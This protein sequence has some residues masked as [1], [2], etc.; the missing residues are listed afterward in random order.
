MP[1]FFGYISRE[2]DILEKEL[3]IYDLIEKKNTLIDEETIVTTPNFNGKLFRNTVNKF[4]GDKVFF[5]KND[6]YLILDG[7][8]L[9][10]HELYK[11]YEI[12]EHNITDLLNKMVT[13][14]PKTF[15]Q[16]F[17]GTFAGLYLNKDGM[18]LYT[19]H[20]GD[21]EIFYHYTE[22]H[23]LYFATDFEVLIKMVHN[24]T[25]K[26]FELNTNAA[27][28]LLTHSHVL[29]NETLFNDV[30]RLTPGH[31]IE[32]ST[33]RFEKKPY[34]ILNNKSVNLTEEEALK[35]ID[36]LFRQAIKRA[37][38]KD[39]EYGYKHLVALSG[40]LDSRMT[41][42][43][44]Y[45]MGYTN[46]LNYTFSQTDYLDETVPKQITSKLKTEW[47]FKA[48]DNGTYLYKYFIDSI[49]ISGARSQSSTIAHTM[50]MISNINLNH[51]GLV[52]TGQIGD[53]V[54]G[55]FY[56][57]GK[58]AGFSRGDG[59]YSNKLIG[60]V[61]YTQ[62]KTFNQEDQEL[63]KFYNRG[64]TGVN[65]GLKPMYQFT[66]TMSPF[67]DIDFMDFC[68]TMPMEFRR[69]HNIYIKW[70]NQ[71]YPEAADFIYEKVKG[72]INRK[73]ITIKGVPVP[74]TS[75][76][77]AAVK[78]IKNRLGLKLKT[79]NHMHPMDYWYENNSEL[80]NFYQELYMESANL[81]KDQELKEDCK[82]I[83]QEGSTLEKD[84][85]ASILGF[86]KLMDKYIVR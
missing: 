47:M 62:E 32:F 76:P 73:L 80:R 40:G 1:G 34:Y 84:Q 79:K 38:D 51:Y 75:I 45:D 16:E 23:R 77:S 66:E 2:K 13:I 30:Y 5:C 64:F 42:W 18:V 67:L 58:R 55:T 33:N 9:N 82:K 49:K 19:N 86:L 22:D 83:F 25:N 72:K 68:L 8:I 56:N 71:Y 59:A 10:K 48:L 63:F 14:N 44:A 20:I 43:V 3:D 39:L 12:K 78:L 17:R 57:N 69:G 29:C 35:K 11:K 6:N 4:Q 61:E 37:F 41:A 74:W 36:S 85:V 53:V 27:Y 24:H 31:Y 21:K 52:H 46:M 60:K 81:I 54:I 15:Y 26:S 65:T 70:I 7:V 28:C 50:S